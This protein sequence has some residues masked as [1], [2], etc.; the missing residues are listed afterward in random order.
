MS[1]SFPQHIAVTPCLSLWLFICYVSDSLLACVTVFSVGR[2][3]SS[4]SCSLLTFLSL[5]L[6]VAYRYV[7]LSQS[8]SQLS[9]E[10]PEVSCLLRDR[11]PRETESGL[12]PRCP[13]QEEEEE[14]KVVAGKVKV[15]IRDEGYVG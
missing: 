13:R 1:G 2:A 7:S 15:E 3:F 6:S 8:P 10:E 11:T 5:L 4:Q 12:M 9:Q 14:E